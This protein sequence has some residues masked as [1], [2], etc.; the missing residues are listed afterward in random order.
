VKYVGKY[1]RNWQW[2]SPS[3]VINR[4]QE[5]RE[6]ANPRVVGGLC[7]ATVSVTYAKHFTEVITL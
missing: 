4:S 5:L 1:K 7:V 6:N 2:I 3:L